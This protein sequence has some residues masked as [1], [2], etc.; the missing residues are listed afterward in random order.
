M[1]GPRNLRGRRGS[2]W[3][4]SAVLVLAAAVAAASSPPPARELL[5]FEEPVVTSVAK[6][7][8][9]LSEAPA[10]VY[11]ITAEA[12]RR[13]G[14]QTIPEL[15]RMVPG[16]DVAR[17]NAH[18]WAVSARGFN[19]EF[20]N[21]LL[22]LIDG[23]SVYSPLFSGVFWDEQNLLLE[24][25]ERIEVIRGPGGTLWG[26]NAVN[27]VINIVT[28]LAKETQGALVTAGGGTEERAIGGVR[29]G[30]SAAEGA[31]HYR[32]YGKYSLWDDQVDSAGM[33][34]NDG[35]RTARGGGRLDWEVSPRDFVT[36]QGDVYHGHIDDTFDR[37][38]LTPPFQ[39]TSRVTR[40]IGGGDILGRW[41]RTWES[42]AATSF[43]A[44]YDRVERNDLIDFSVDTVDAQLQQDFPWGERQSL[45]A[46][47]G[48]RAVFDR[49]R[50]SFF[51][52]GTPSH[53]QADL[54]DAFLQDD[55]TLVPGRLH[56]VIGSKIEHN[57]FSGFEYEPGVRLLW[58]ARAQLTLW[59]AV[60]RAVQTPDRSTDDARFNFLAFPD[61]QGR[62]DLVSLFGN[63]STDSEKLLAYEA[64]I[65]MRPAGNLFLDLAVFYHDY[66]DLRVGAPEAPFL[67]ED[68]PPA[69]VV[70]PL[71]ALNLMRGESHGLEIASTWA[72]TPR[73]KLMASYSYLGVALDSRAAEHAGENLEDASPHNQVQ[74]R[75]YLDLPANFE[76][77]AALYYVDAITVPGIVT[78]QRVPSHTRVDAR[79]GWQPSPPLELSVV[80]RNAL[81][82][83]HPEFT[84]FVR[85]STQVQRSV[86]GKLTYRW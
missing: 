82:P 27:G 51:A 30:G 7:A 69:H 14:M 2:W 75:S 46:G 34:A 38:I 13:S 28:K 29:Y 53:Y 8:Q 17:I 5:L 37:A 72:V 56:L 18:T 80:L 16:L 31:L 24:D 74:L 60:S 68:P 19:G 59:A 10:A 85:E 62:V 65:R 73:W 21:K 36:V 26:A 66:R 44:Y 58:T 61:P 50:N 35:W 33:D 45:V 40:A 12:I 86:F 83:E 67:E 9:A 70:M 41:R 6:R 63:R 3:F 47:L 22:V 55:V 49:V 11:V 76:A 25:V 78:S 23:R 77:D 52:A 71:R 4:C 54:F 1:H 15:L 43:Q 81:D 84:S 32:L 42:G 20:S 64:G 79:L 48:Y 57:D 39:R